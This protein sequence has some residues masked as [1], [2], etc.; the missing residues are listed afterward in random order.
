MGMTRVTARVVSLSRTGVPYEADFLVDTGAIHCMA[1]RD[2][3]LAAGVQPE[4]KT[5]YELATGEPVE[6]EHGFA[7]ISFLG[8]ETVTRVIF[9]PPGVEPLLGVLA[10]EDAGIVVDPRT[11]ELRKLDIL[12]LKRGLLA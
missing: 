7:R 10:L 5:V 9:G 6:L 1:P 2:R 3:L 8:M 12:P 4:G 11:Q